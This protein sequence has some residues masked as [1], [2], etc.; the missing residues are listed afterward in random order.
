MPV[1][2]EYIDMPENLIC[3]YQYFTEADIGKLRS[4][5]YK[6]EFRSLEESVKDYC[7]YLDEN[8]CL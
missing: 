4:V 6:R 7:Y 3:Q 5:G 1:N 8:K 2:I